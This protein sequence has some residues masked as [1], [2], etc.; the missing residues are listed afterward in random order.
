MWKKIIYEGVE[1]NYSV[2]DIGEVRKDTNNY[3]MK[4]QI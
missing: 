3:I 1:T 2:S 4:Q